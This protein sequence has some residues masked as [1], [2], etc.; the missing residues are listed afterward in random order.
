M[1]ENYKIQRELYELVAKDI[2]KRYKYIVTSHIIDVAISIMMHRDKIQL[3]GSFVE[4]ICNNDLDNSCS[5]ADDECI[6]FLRYFSL[7]KK[8]GFI[9]NK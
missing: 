1:I 2:A 5:R 7:V 6:S 8:L 9:A 3:G 4:A